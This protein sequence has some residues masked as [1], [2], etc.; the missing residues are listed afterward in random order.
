M[1]LGL[2]EYDAMTMLLE[3]QTRGVRRKARSRATRVANWTCQIVSASAARREQFA[4]A[5]EAAGWEVAVFRSAD[6]ATS[7]AAR[8]R[9]G[10]TMLDLAGLSPDEASAFRRCAEQVASAAESL[11]MLCGQ[12]GDALEEIWARQL[13]VWLYLPGVDA[14][15]DLASLCAEAKQVAGKPRLAASCY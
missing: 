3:P 7:A 1:S 8:Q 5:A 11:V 4:S 14:S 13:G 6:A 12:D 10:L 15:S 9:Y 2:A